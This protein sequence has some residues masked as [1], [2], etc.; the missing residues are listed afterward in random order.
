MSVT[1][2]AKC[3]W[4][5]A[6]RQMPS[7]GS[8][9]STRSL[10]KLWISTPRLITQAGQPHHWPSSTDRLGSTLGFVNL[11]HP[12]CPIS[13]V[14]PHSEQ[15]VFRLSV[16]SPRGKGRQM[17]ASHIPALDLFF[18]PISRIW[19]VFNQC[20]HPVWRVSWKSPNKVAFH[21]C[22]SLWRCGVS[23]YHSCL[24]LGTLNFWGHWSQLSDGW[25][26]SW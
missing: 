26:A 20:L 18:H 8:W 17:S 5:R 15:D 14:H 4:E 11:S 19:S 24:Y 12:G 6:G 16:Q 3:M 23:L 9:E 10:T 21:F 22:S 13:A 1:A 25:W 2:V 7:L